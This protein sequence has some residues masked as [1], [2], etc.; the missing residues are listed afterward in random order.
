MNTFEAIMD[1]PEASID[2]SYMQIVLNRLSI[3]PD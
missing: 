3:R 2:D 1:H